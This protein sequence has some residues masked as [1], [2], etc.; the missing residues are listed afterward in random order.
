MGIGNAGRKFV[1]DTVKMGL[2]DFNIG[3]LEY[4]DTDDSTQNYIF[5]NITKSRCEIILKN[6]SDL[7]GQGCIF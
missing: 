2:F 5:Q 1:F 4:H 3:E 6:Q 7:Y